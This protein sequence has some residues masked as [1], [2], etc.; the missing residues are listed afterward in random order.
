MERRRWKQS[1]RDIISSHSCDDCGRIKF[2]I[3]DPHSAGHL[4]FPYQ[5]VLKYAGNGCDFFAR[6][7]CKLGFCDIPGSHG[8]TLELHISLTCVDDKYDKPKFHYV[9]ISWM[10]GK[11]F[12]E[13]VESDEFHAFTL[14]GRS[15]LSITC[16]NLNKHLLES[17]L[18]QYIPTRPCEPLVFSLKTKTDVKRW[19][20]DC[21][22]NHTLCKWVIG[23]L[24]FKERPARLVALGSE[25]VH[26]EETDTKFPRAYVALSY[27]WGEANPKWYTT[28]QNLDSYLERIEGD[29]LPNTIKHAMY[30]TQELGYEYLWVDA[31]CIIQEGNENDKT[32]ELRKMAS[33]YYG[34]S[35]VLSAAR[36]RSSGVGFLQDRK[37][38]EIYNTVFKLRAIVESVGT[39]TFFLHERSTNDSTNEPIDKRGW[40]LQEH[41]L[42]VRLL[43]FGSKQTSWTC[44]QKGRNV[45]GG[46]AFRETTI[47]PI[48]F[49]GKLS[50]RLLEDHN[51]TPDEWKFDN[52]ME[53][54]HEYSSRKVSKI[55]D[56]LR[57]L[58]ALAQMFAIEAQ[59]DTGNYCAGLWRDDLPKHLLWRRVNLKKHAKTE[60][61]VI[62]RSENSNPSWSWV[63]VGGMVEHYPSDV[64]RKRITLGNIECRIMLEDQSL[65]YGEVQSA[66]LILDG[67]LREVYLDGYVLYEPS[68]DGGKGTICS[69][70]LEPVFDQPSQ[71]FPRLVWLL[72]IYS[73]PLLNNAYGLILENVKDS[74]DFKRV[75]Y[76]E[77]NRED[78]LRVHGKQRITIL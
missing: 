28:Q 40:T 27:C 65:P 1:T 48:A 46:C 44:P 3:T 16:L 52:W 9:D 26:L 4:S 13:E 56:R 60:R 58:A 64:D 77:I 10:H 23:A 72:H 74:S 51:K 15:S 78:W 70:E 2:R 17:P 55:S 68:L 45:D 67:Y 29:I 38:D 18:A 71:S 59:V 19:L 39:Y 35:V 12:S 21:Q 47:D 22:T 11:E 66:K 14:E 50:Q 6:T 53:V 5:D 32:N 7:L 41:S 76:F 62:E 33:I 69:L 25:T 31:L 49:T 24:P 61:L 20:H 34:A 57:A 73:E 43:R 42:A 30:I 8:K 54:V 75:G 36:A 37:L 63:S